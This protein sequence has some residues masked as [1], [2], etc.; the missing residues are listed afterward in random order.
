MQEIFNSYQITEDLYARL[1]HY[2]DILKNL[3][4]KLKEHL[5]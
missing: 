3:K 1:P 4:N 2:L 5:E